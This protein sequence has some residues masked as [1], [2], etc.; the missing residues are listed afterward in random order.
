ML[1]VTLVGLEGEHATFNGATGTI[2]E[3]DA[4]SG[5]YGVETV[6][7]DALP[8]PAGC[9]KLADGAVGTVHGLQSAPQYN[10]SLARVLSHDDDA[11]RYVAEMD[12]GRQLRLKRANLLA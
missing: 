8:V 10:G 11:G 12:G 6:G 1:S 4:T 5:L 9:A 7:G 2:F 3:Y